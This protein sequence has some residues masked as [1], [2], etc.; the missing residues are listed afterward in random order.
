MYHKQYIQKEYLL[1]QLSQFV[2][3]RFGLI[4]NIRFRETPVLHVPTAVS[5]AQNRLGFG[6]DLDF[7]T[8]V[9]KSMAEAL[10]RYAINC[11]KKQETVIY[12]KTYKEMKALGYLCFYPDH[13][14]FEDSVYTNF[15]FCKQITPD[16]KTDWAPAR[17]LSDNQL[18]LLPA[19]LLYYNGC[20]TL[21]NVLKSPTSSGMACS[22]LN[23]AVES[24]LLEL[25]ERDT[26]LY[27]WLSKSPG[28]EVIFDKI[29]N[30]RLKKMLEKIDCK[31]R[32]IKIVFKHTDIQIPCIFVLFKG[33]KT[34]DEPAF[35]ITGTADTDVERGCYRALSEFTQ[36]Y[37]GCLLNKRLQER[38]EQ[39][40]K[41]PSPKMT[42]FMDHTAF[43]AI[44]ENF[45]KLEF[46]F[47][48]IG[49]RKLSEL[50][51]KW[52]GDPNENLLKTAL[53]HKNI[54]IADVTPPEIRQSAVYVMRS[55]SPDLMDIDYRD[56]Q[57]FSSSF[58]K[59]RVD[60][61]DK[62]LNTQTDRLN[63]DPHV[64]G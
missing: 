64:Y 39:M 58:R 18:V 26:M 46:L 9:I 44:Y 45:Y 14:E 17:R 29:Q 15:P 41:E 3:S 38:S 21:T 13:P 59:K 51:E 34:Y 33:K 10:E 50:S 55:Y 61:I 40:A 30:S 4:Q 11:P 48:D 53:K 28:E 24:S 62:A 16:L 7:S 37:N 5:R 23:S 22:F 1:D 36:C 8:A 54:F 42:G 43:Y 60:M 31:R 27:M 6:T 20:N 19:S 57:M 35:L 25:I 32:Q 56:D 12:K 52:K 47:N 63:P 2:S 49:K